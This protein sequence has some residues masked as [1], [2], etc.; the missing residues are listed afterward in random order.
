MALR[1]DLYDSILDFHET[2]CRLSATSEGNGT[3]RIHEWINNSPN[4]TEA[5]LQPTNEVPRQQPQLILSGS[6]F[7]RNKP[8]L[9]EPKLL[10]KQLLQI[11]S[12]VLLFY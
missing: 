7:H 8:K 3:E 10:M 2:L 5:N 4:G 12:P 9:P 11:L 6:K 1:E